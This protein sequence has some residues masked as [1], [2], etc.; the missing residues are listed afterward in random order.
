MFPQFSISLSIIC[1]KQLPKVKA[2][3][4]AGKRND[5][6]A[7]PPVDAKTTHFLVLISEGFREARGALS[8]SGANLPS[9][10][11][12]VK[13]DSASTIPV[14][15]APP[16]TLPSVNGSFANRQ[17]IPAGTVTPATVK[18]EPVPV[19]SMVTGSAFHHNSSVA[20]PTSTVQGVPSL[21][22]FSP[23]SVSQDIMTINE[24]ANSLFKPSRKLF[25]NSTCVVAWCGKVN[26][27]A[28]A[29]EAC[30]SDPSS[31]LSPSFW[32]HVHIVIPERPT[33]CAVFNVISDSPPIWTHPSQEPAK[34][35]LVTSCWQ[36]EHEWRQNIS[37]ATE[38]LSAVS[39][40]RWISSKSGVLA[41]SNSVFEKNFTSPTIDTS[42]PTTVSSS[43]N[44]MHGTVENPGVMVF[45]IKEIVT[46]LRNQAQGSSSRNS[47]EHNARG[48]KQM[49]L[50]VVDAADGTAS[51]SCVKEHVVKTTL[52][53]SQ[54]S[55][56]ATPRDIEDFGRSLRP[57]TFLHY[58]FSTLNQFQSKKNMDINPID[59]DVNKFKV[60]D[61]VGDRQFD[62]NHG[63]RSY[64]YTYTVEDV[65]VLFLRTMVVVTLT[66]VAAFQSQFMR[67]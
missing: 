49:L 41:N 48:E 64:G 4:D 52:D 12:P 36:C 56:V 51:A 28:Y 34:F 33:E 16:T 15:G 18:V 30:I 59:Q 37:V 31:I 9:N 10:Q 46:E 54:S 7:D 21:Q 20:R 25:K 3:Y 44:T 22:T 58:N 2:I 14:T 45:A 27:I 42:A 39:P 63:Q 26:A 43:C 62:S 53:A 23:S 40:Y 50:E 47:S 17:P 6:A 66:L 67:Q 11:S 8:R 1:P 65:L 60:S 55:Q 32:I 24:N 61:D 29:S 35:V 57:N 5:R 19:T 38:W 13:V